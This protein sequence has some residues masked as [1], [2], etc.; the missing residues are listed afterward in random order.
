VDVLEIQLLV[1]VDVYLMEL[2]QVLVL[3]MV[4]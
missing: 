2:V 4:A 1:P 3:V